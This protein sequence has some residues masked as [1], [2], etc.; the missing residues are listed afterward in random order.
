MASDEQGGRNVTGREDNSRTRYPRVTQPRGS[1]EE[2]QDG[3]DRHGH[4]HLPQWTVEV[5]ECASLE[6]IPGPQCVVGC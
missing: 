5:G 6:Q 2:H 3:E 4:R 1:E